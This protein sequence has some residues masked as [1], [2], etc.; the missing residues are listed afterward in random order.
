M[1]KDQAHE[2]FDLQFLD[3]FSPRLR[4]QLED[5]EN[6]AESSP[7]ASLTISR[8]FSELLLR[9][10][11]KRNGAPPQAKGE[12][13]WKFINRLR[14][15]GYIPQEQANLFHAIREAG[16][17]GAHDDADAS[18]SQARQVVAQAKQLAFWFA[19]EKT[20]RRQ[21]SDWPPLPPPPPPV[22][23]EDYEEAGHAGV[24]SKWI[25]YG[26]LASL[27]FALALVVI[28]H[29]DVTSSNI[30]IPSP[31]T[32]ADWRAPN[33]L[34]ATGALIL[35][36]GSIGLI[37]WLLP[38]ILES[39]GEVKWF[40]A[41][42][43]VLVILGVFLVIA[44]IVNPPW[45]ADRMSQMGKAFPAHAAHRVVTTASAALTTMTCAN[46]AWGDAREKQY[47]DFHAKAWLPVNTSII[48]EGTDG[49]M[50]IDDTPY[51]WK[52]YP[53]SGVMVEAGDSGTHRIGYWLGDGNCN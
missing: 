26:V 53:G 36:V 51:S 1:Q 17:A 20:A 34:I 13:A 40:N 44:W 12:E 14:D 25:V 5:A 49:R 47:C 30:P 3:K 9:A 6:L 2:D 23:E 29:F 31:V 15:S 7:D 4:K 11:A 45:F 37:V 10:I 19:R 43:G 8:K 18:S 48:P 41:G 38:K 24:I 39:A 50:C 22:G 27:L 35:I 42:K 32:A 33:W 16:N 21:G 46:F 28:R 52:A